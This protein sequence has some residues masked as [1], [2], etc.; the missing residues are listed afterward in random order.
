M[1]IDVLRASSSIITAIGNGCREVIPTDTVDGATDIAQRL[2]RNEVCLCGERGGRIVKGFHIGNSPSEYS[3]EAIGGKT[4]VYTSTN[5][6]RAIL[7]SR[8]TSLG[9]IGAFTNASAVVDSALQGDDDL[10]VLC[11]GQDGLFSLEDTVCGGMLITRILEHRGS[12]DKCPLNDAA[13]A[14]QVLFRAYAHSIPDMLRAS[15]HG[16]DLSQIGFGDD[17]AYCAAVDTSTIVPILI[18]GRIVKGDADLYDRLRAA[19]RERQGG[20]TG[21]SSAPLWQSE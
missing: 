13:V 17:L 2:G 16:E 14:A 11:A 8:N 10:I 18:G 19:L 3:K 21:T 15:S 7:K 5:G 1:V 12:G 20:P 4:L 6:S 9:M